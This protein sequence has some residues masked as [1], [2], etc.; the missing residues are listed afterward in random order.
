MPKLLDACGDFVCVDCTQTETCPSGFK[1]IIQHPSGLTISFQWLA[2]N[3][4]QHGFMTYPQAEVL[5]YELHEALQNWR[6]SGRE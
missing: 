6:A 3:Q 5:E 1:P 2:I 4:G